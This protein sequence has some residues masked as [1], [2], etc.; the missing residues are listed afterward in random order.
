MDPGSGQEPPEDVESL[1]LTREC[2]GSGTE[3]K[4]SDRAPLCVQETHSL[5]NEGKRE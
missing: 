2:E 4:I 5:G 1:P 3:K